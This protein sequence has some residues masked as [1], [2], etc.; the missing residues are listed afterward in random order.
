MWGTV[1]RG[2]DN[3]NEHSRNMHMQKHNKSMSIVLY[4]YTCCSCHV[5][6]EKVDIFESSSRPRYCDLRRVTF[7]DHY[8]G[9]MVNS[10][11]G[12]S[13][14]SEW[15]EKYFRELGQIAKIFSPEINPLAIRHTANTN[16]LLCPT[17][18]V[19]CH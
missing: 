19:L 5:G 18:Q 10:S 7:Y 11:I 3:Y 13:S 6:K 4:K 15:E 8:P 1:Q 9:A 12:Y 16:C 17:V 14:W 2:K